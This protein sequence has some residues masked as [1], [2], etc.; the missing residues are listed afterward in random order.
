[1]VRSVRK[2]SRTNTSIRHSKTDTVTTATKTKTTKYQQD[3]TRD[4]RLVAVGMSVLGVTFLIGL[5]FLAGPA[6]DTTFWQCG[7]FDMTR[8][9][10]DS[11]PTHTTALWYHVS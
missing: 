1:M 10:S 7:G 6:F 2:I 11:N 4:I 9:Q 5:I 8:F 3:A